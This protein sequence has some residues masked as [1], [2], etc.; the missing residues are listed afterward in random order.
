MPYNE[1]AQ[2]ITQFPAMSNTLNDEKHPRYLSP[3]TINKKVFPLYFKCVHMPTGLLN[4]VFDLYQYASQ[5]ISL[6]PVM[7]VAFLTFTVSSS[8]CFFVPKVACVFSE[9][10]HYGSVMIAMLYLPQYPS[11]QF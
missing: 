8:S 9:L 6:S 10:R 3:D 5:S 2:V 7:I 4:R 11:G 1:L